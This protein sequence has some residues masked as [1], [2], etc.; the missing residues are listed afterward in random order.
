[1]PFAIPANVKLAENIK[2]QLIVF[3]QPAKQNR[4]TWQVLAGEKCFWG[5]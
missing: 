4:F 2:L 3:S 1:M 5:G